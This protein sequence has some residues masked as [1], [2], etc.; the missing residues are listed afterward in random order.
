MLG[1]ELVGNKATVP[2]CFIHHTVGPQSQ[3]FALTTTSTGTRVD[4]Y[5]MFINQHTIVSTFGCQIPAQNPSSLLCQKPIPYKV[6]VAFSK[7]VHAAMKGK[8][9]PTRCPLWHFYSQAQQPPCACHSACHPLPI[10]S[11]S[12]LTTRSADAEPMHNHTET[13]FTAQCAVW[14]NQKCTAGF[15]GLT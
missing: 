13:I 2:R 15:K 6:R 11:I 1:V 14:C 9:W 12:T 3:A 4:I 5:T 8:N 10:P 7:P